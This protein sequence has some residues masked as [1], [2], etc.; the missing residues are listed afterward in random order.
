MEKEITK[1]FKRFQRKRNQ[2]FKAHEK[3][4][5]ELNKWFDEELQKITNGNRKIIRKN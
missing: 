5:E 4:Q 1:L 2:L 3:L